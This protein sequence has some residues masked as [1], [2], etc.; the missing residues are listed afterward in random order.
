MKNLK[1]YEED[2][3]KCSRCALCQSVCPVYKATL[4]EC[5][6][7]KGKFNILNGVVKGDLTINSQIKKYLDF[8]TG[9]NACRD[10]CPSGID[11]HG[12]FVA[13][14]NEYHKQCVLS[15]SERLFSSYSLF[16]IILNILGVFS[17][18]YNFLGLHGLIKILRP[19]LLK[20]G[21]LGQRILLGDCL[22]SNKF[23][24]KIRYR[25]R[26]NSVT[27]KAI[28]FEGC[29]NKYLNSESKNA[30]FTL[31]KNMNISLK[32]KRFECCGISYLNDGNICEFKKIIDKNLAQLDCDYD[33]IITDCASCND[34]LKS[35]V[36]YA[37]SKNT[38][39]AKNLNEKLVNVLDLIKGNKFELK[40]SKSINVAVHVPC[41]EFFDVKSFV[42]SINGINFVKT[43]SDEDCCG[44]AGSFAIKYSEAS[45][46]ISKKKVL[47]YINAGVDIVLTTCPACVLGLEQGFLQAD[48]KKRPVVMNL[49]T[50]LAKYCRTVF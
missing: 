8:C 18:F 23:R 44:F 39:L 30:V 37:D 17:K 41:H 9:C 31:L 5:A 29:F 38:H 36:D 16:K 45:M 26:I 28:F 7:S 49:V 10:F 1:D 2:L 11:A 12:I 15:V 21:I 20:F 50:F 33:Y 27:P 6:V 40:M 47:D 22:I 43:D 32:T 34:V 25:N 4:N 14:K 3:Y 46:K 42:G 24:K 48:V 35:Y 13:A 19:V